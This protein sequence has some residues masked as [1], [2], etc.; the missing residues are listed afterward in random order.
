MTVTTISP[1]YLSALTTPSAPQPN[2]LNDAGL[3]AQPEKNHV[4][5]LLGR[6]ERNDINRL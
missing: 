1:M 4:L 5:E 6:P 2:K 3:V